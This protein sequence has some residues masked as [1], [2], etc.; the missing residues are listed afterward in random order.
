MSYVNCKYI[1]GIDLKIPTQAASSMGSFSGEIKNGETSIRESYKI[2]EILAISNQIENPVF[3]DIGS[4][5]GGYSYIT[6]LNPNLKV[7]AF[8]PNPNVYPLFKDIISKNSIPNI[9]VN[10]FGLSDDNRQ[11]SLHVVNPANIGAASIKVNTQG[12]CF[13]KPLDSLNVDRIDIVKIDVEGHELEVLEG[14]FETI[15]RCK[16]VFLQIEIN[17]GNISHKL[18]L[19]KNKYLGGNYHSYKLGVDYLFF[20]KG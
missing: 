9:T 14:G 1:N 4:N 6:L 17:K 10:Q 18:D 20:R 16:P 19:I 7:Q 5:F 15:K 3:F 8:E 13:F 12:D 11:C 2:K